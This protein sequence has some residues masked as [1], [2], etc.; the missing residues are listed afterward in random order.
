MVLTGI[1]GSNVRRSWL[2]EHTKE[3]LHV[4]IA[5]PYRALVVLFPLKLKLVVD[6]FKWLFKMKA[7]KLLPF[8]GRKILI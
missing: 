7:I 4:P 6:I 5:L 1:E 2:E 3:I 8:N